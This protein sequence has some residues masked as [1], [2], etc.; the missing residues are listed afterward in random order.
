M[1][2]PGYRTP[3]S[4]RRSGVGGTFGGSLGDTLGRRLGRSIFRSGHLDGVRTVGSGNLQKRRRAA[5]YRGELGDGA[6]EHHPHGKCPVRR[7]KSHSAAGRNQNLARRGDGGTDDVRPDCGGSP[8]IFGPG[9]RRI[10]QCR[11]GDHSFI[12]GGLC[13]PRYGIVRLVGRAGR[14]G[15]NDG[16]RDGIPEEPAAG[17]SSGTQ[18][19]NRRLS[20]A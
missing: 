7:R 18:H 2:D 15:G 13:H 16:R 4:I 11:G 9:G 14:R 20:S 6:V 12:L 19:S 10:P 8:G 5:Q 17:S 1:A 3:S